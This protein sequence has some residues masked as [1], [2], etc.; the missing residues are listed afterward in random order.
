[1]KTKLYR[2]STDRMI[3]WVSAGLALLFLVA[4][5]IYTVAHHRHL[6]K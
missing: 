5:S 2:S 3:A 1:M 4:L 6:T